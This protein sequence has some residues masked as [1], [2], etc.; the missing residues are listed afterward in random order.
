MKRRKPSALENATTRLG[1]RPVT[2]QARLRARALKLA[3]HELGDTNDSTQASDQ[4]GRPTPR[5]IWAQVHQRARTLSPAPPG[6]ARAGAPAAALGTEPKADSGRAAGQT[7]PPEPQGAS[8][9][10]HRT[11]ERASRRHRHFKPC[12]K[13]GK[14]I[15]LTHRRL[16]DRLVAEAVPVH[17]WRC[18]SCGWSG[19]RVDRHE[20]KHLK[21]RVGRLII[22]LL[23]FLLGFLLM[24]YLDYLKYTYH[25]PE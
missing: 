20:L 16:L 11:A 3:R 23:A 18:D 21:R 13:C 9:L 19:L 24:S 14:P 10:D 5:A 15:R 2:F 4:A 25:P 17:R 7:Q 1:R 12:P 22:I 8:A 6:S